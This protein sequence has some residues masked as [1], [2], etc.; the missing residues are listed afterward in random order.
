MVKIIARLE[1]DETISFPE[2]HKLNN[3]TIEEDYMNIYLLDKTGS[4]WWN[5]TQYLTQYRD[6]NEYY[7]NSKGKWINPKEDFQYDLNKL[8]LD[9]LTSYLNDGIFGIGFDPNCHYYDTS[10]KFTIETVESQNPPSHVPEP[11]TLLLMGIGLAAIA[12]IKRR[13]Q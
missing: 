9:A 12:G 8:Q 13:L 5:T 1:L 2:G 10:I 7:S 6:E 11:A 4:E 3:W